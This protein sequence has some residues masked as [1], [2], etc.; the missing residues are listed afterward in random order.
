[1]QG[2][3]IW[4]NN[5][6]AL[7]IETIY[8]EMQSLSK[9][10]LHSRSKLLIVWGTPGFQNFDVGYKSLEIQTWSYIMS[11]KGL[12]TQ[13]ICECCPCYLSIKIKIK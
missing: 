13:V 9:N 1:M 4:R 11:I 8:R 3:N 6:F 5:L 2:H 7:S 10:Y 12:Q